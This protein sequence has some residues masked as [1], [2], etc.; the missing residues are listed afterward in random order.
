M[1]PPQPVRT[2]ATEL[3]DRRRLSQKTFEIRLKRPKGFSFAAGQRICLYH[4]KLDRDYSLVSAPSDPDLALCI[5]NV[6][7]GSMSSVLSVAEAGSRLN[8]TGP[9]GYFTFRPSRRPAIFVATGTGIAP[10]R[11]MV[12]SGIT[13]FTLFHG[14]EKPEE[15][16]Y[17][18]EFKS[19]SKLYVPCISGEVQPSSGF[20]QGRVTDYIRKKLPPAAYDFYLCGRREMIRDVTL[21]VDD[22]FSASLVYTE[23]F[24]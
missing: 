9:H 4:Q 24:Y 8:F 10:F 5:R 3:C 18:S 7:A 13:Q 23:I 20:F 11:A 15:L 12:Q 14:V 1:K 22:L 2:Y 21:L 17:A 19:S 6:K 16:Y